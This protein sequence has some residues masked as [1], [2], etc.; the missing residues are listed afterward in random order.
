MDLFWRALVTQRSDDCESDTGKTE[1]FGH[2][3]GVLA[4]AE[5]PRVGK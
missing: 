4:T 5:V 1:W 2:F 3:F